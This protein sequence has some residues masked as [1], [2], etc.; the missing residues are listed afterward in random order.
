[1]Y[2]LK[3]VC[4]VFKSPKSHALL[5]LTS[6][7]LTTVDRED[8]YTTQTRTVFVVTPGP[9]SAPFIFR[10]GCMAFRWRGEGRTFLRSTSMINNLCF[11]FDGSGPPAKKALRAA[12][13]KSSCLLRKILETNS[14]EK[15]CIENCIENGIEMQF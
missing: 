8:F 7:S 10:S 15:N 4:G 13:P 5:K 12:P 1:M 6:A 9:I 3:E 14:E 2:Q 11:W